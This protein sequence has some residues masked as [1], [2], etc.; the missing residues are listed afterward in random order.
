MR[1]PVKAEI[2]KFPYG[3]KAALTII[4]DDGDFPTGQHLR[5]LARNFHFRPSVAGVV[6]NIYPHLDW[7]QDNET[8]LEMLNH[9]WSHVG[10]D[11]NCPD[12]LIEHEYFDAKRFFERHFKTP[13]FTFVPPFNYIP[14]AGYAALKRVN[15]LAAR[16]WRN[17]FNSPDPAYGSGP[18]EWLNLHSFGIGDAHTP[19]ERNKW[20]KDVVASGGWL[21]EMWHN[22]Y[23]DSPANYQPLHLEKAIAHLEF[24][25]SLPELWIASFTEAVS[26]F[27][28]RKFLQP[29]SWL[30]DDFLHVKL[31]KTRPDL[32]WE[33]FSSPIHIALDIPGHLLSITTPVALKPKTV[34]E[35]RPGNCVKRAKYPLKK[36]QP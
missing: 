25:R 22:V 1:Y 18:G 7:W 10:M 3:K 8:W 30:E 21:I 14:P 32:P 4:S 9:S 11:E 36:P 15:I 12:W 13:Q 16:Q 6:E 2:L 27:Y 34:L 19:D 20:L 35:L 33:Q 24:A 23:T 28:Q 31:K 29:I 17:S 26:W 5:K